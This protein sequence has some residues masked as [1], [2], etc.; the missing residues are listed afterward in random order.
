LED[1]YIARR[2]HPD[3][4]RDDD[5]YSDNTYN[6]PRRGSRDAKPRGRDRDDYYDGRRRERSDYTE[7]R[8]AK[9]KKKGSRWEREA[10]DLFAQYAVPALKAEAGKYATKQ[11]GKLFT[12]GAAR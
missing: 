7:D 9:P 6:R 12:G 5:Y 2:R 3:R 10:K 8:P 4:H 1:E 11:I